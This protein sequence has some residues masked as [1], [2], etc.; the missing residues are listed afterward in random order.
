MAYVPI[1]TLSM[2]N[3]KPMFLT[4]PPDGSFPT[5]YA[6]LLPRECPPLYTPNL[7]GK[8]PFANSSL[9]ACSH[10]MCL[11]ASAAPEHVERAVRVFLSLLQR[12]ETFWA[13]RCLLLLLLP[14]MGYCDLEV[15]L[16]PTPP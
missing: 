16:P 13:L 3:L 4:F 5:Y 12:D 2:L 6:H 10:A 14:S 15:P 1:F 11:P 8:G 7:P 9:L